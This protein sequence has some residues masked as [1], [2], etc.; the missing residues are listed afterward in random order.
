MSDPDPGAGARHVPVLSAEVLDLLRPAAGEV[1]VDAT[2]G[3]GG[4]TRLLAQRLLPGGRL[5]A[6]D[7]DPDMIELA[8]PRLEGLPVT[9]VHANFDRLSDVLAGHGLQRV[10][11]ILADLGVC[12]DQLDDAGR[13]L[14]FSQE[15]PLD[16]RLDPGSGEPASALL[17]RLSERDL[18]D[19][20]WRYGEE[21][22]SRRIARRV[23]EERRRTPLE[24]T[25]QL[26]DLVRRCVP[27][28]RPG[29]RPGID[30]ATRVFQALRIAVNDELGALDRLLAALPGCIRPGGRVALISF[31]SLEDRR[32]K[33]ALRQRE[34]WEEL[35]RK[36]VQVGDEEVRRNP[37]ARSAKLRAARRK[38]DPAPAGGARLRQEV[39]G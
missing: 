35:T 15:G 29:R 7:R 32:V 38:D 11:G 28:P 6:L 9:L 39:Q 24:T 25:G 21:R 20:F 33:Q 13:G 22:F 30:P 17:R 36:P 4:H 23:V 31:H 26:A 27:R 12:S 18:A 5:I 10:D 34:T 14:S 8:R 19:L 3:A 16:M 37:R 1:F 2:L